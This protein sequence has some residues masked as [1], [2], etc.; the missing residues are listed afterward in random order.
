MNELKQISV[1]TI[2]LNYKAPLDTIE[3]INSLKAMS[4]ENVDF[5]IVLIDNCSQDDSCKIFN[6]L[7]QYDEHVHL[8]FNSENNGYAAGN[9]KGIKFALDHNADYIWVLNNDTIA[10]VNC[11]K[12]LLIAE[13]NNICA[14][15]GAKVCDYYNK[16]KVLY[17]NYKLDNYLRNT[18]SSNIT[19]EESGCND[20]KAEWL[21]GCSLFAKSQIFK[22]HL[23]DERYFLYGEDVAYSI[24]LK[25]SKINLIL[26]GKS[27]IWHKESISTNR[28]SNLKLY[29]LWRN[30]MIVAA[31]YM[32]NPYKMLYFIKRFMILP[33]RLLRR[34][35]KGIFL[36]EEYKD[37]VKYEWFAVKDFLLK[38][39]GKFNER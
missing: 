18:C 4:K 11:L 34:Y 8:I 16:E 10:D 5:N 27:L 35:V 29:Y 14:M 23:I 39:D 15:I 1:Y 22:E 31:L 32:K 33:F 17:W 19:I 13:K 20:I 26:S 37:Y 36:K 28:I 3:C 25:N 2:L 38:K 30:E 21:S 6:E 24:E 7:Y 12:E 9:N